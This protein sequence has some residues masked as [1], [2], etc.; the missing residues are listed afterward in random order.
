MTMLPHMGS[1][2]LPQLAVRVRLGTPSLMLQPR[3]RG[4]DLEKLLGEE[5]RLCPTFL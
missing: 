2:D 3:L 5:T 1:T 4:S